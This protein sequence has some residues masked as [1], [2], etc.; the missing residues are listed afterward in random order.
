MGD[1]ESNLFNLRRESKADIIIL[2]AT[3]ED[4]SPSKIAPDYT[5]CERDTD[6]ESGDCGIAGKLVDGVRVGDGWYINADGERV[7]VIAGEG[8]CVTGGES[9]RPGEV[10]RITKGEYDDLNKTVGVIRYNNSRDTFIHE[11]GHLFGLEHNIE[12]LCSYD[13]EDC[14]IRPK[15]RHGHVSLEK[16]VSTVMA[17]PTTC[18][19]LSDEGSCKEINI[20][21]NPYYHYEGVAMGGEYERFAAC[22]IEKQEIT[23]QIYMN[24]GLVKKIM[25]PALGQLAA[26]AFMVLILRVA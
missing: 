8:M 7:R 18:R 19:K 11:A 9:R 4:K 16:N 24:I 10:G 13:M 14:D 21:S 12:R 1:P 20:F 25:L 26:E 23:F 15:L 17:H 3:Y 22:F 6:C 5:P 2:L